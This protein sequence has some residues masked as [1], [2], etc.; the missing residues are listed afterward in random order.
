VNAGGSSGN[1]LTDWITMSVP[2][3]QKVSHPRRLDSGVKPHKRRVTG[4]IPRAKT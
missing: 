1:G 3:K 2:D 4:L